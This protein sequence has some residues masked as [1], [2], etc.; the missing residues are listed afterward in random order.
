MRSL[1]V[2]ILSLFAVLAFFRSPVSADAVDATAK[3]CGP[4]L[5]ANGSFEKGSTPGEWLTIKAGS[6]DL[7]GWTVSK[8]TVDIVGTLWPASD[9]DRSIDL[10]GTSFGAISQDV[11]TDPGKT[12]VVTFD[13]SGN[14]YG[15]PTIKTMQLSAGDDSTQLSFDVSKRPYRSMGWQTHTWRF[16]AKGKSTTIEFESLDTVNGYYGPLIDNV[17]VQATCD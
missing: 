14:A 13:F 12:Y 17:H 11:K 16:V 5:I 9:G 2:C 1:R 8:G 4:N 10:D 7:D 3:P 6:S 15:P